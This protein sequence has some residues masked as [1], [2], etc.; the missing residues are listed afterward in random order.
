MY[1]ND[2]FLLSNTG[3]GESINIET[4]DGNNTWYFKADG[5]LQLPNGG[6]IVDING[7]SVLGGGT[8]LPSNASGYLVNDGSGNLSWAAG[9]GTF[10]GDYDDLTNKPTIPTDVS[11]LTDT[12]N[13]LFSGSYNDLS[14]TPALFDGD[15]TNLTN[16][17]ALFDGDYTSLANTPSLFSGDYDDLTS[18]PALFDGAYSSLTG[19]PALFS[20]V[21]AD[22]TSK[23][24]LFDGDY[25]SLTNKPTIRIAVPT[26]SGPGGNLQADSLA[27]AGLNPVTDIPST[28]GGDLILQGGVGGANGDLYGEVRIKSGQ[29]GANYEWHFTTDK[30]IKLPAGGDIVN[31]TG[32]SVMGGSGSYAPAVPANWASPA[33]TTIAEALDRIA[34]KLGTL[35]GDLP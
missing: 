11:D 28:W 15:Y 9:D 32:T 17:P 30:K 21:Y 1:A 19:T 14:N 20:G 29:I 7:N 3:A 5:N 26:G 10:S 35:G 13:L 24:T 16:T 27:L 23:P 2:T 6:T 12:T 8:T 18:K 25:N 22:L 4:N 33:P 34:A 31:S